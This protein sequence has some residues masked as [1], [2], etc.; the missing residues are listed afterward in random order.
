MNDFKVMIGQSNIDPEERTRQLAEVY[1]YILSWQKPKE[2]NDPS[3]DS[4]PRF[5]VEGSKDEQQLKKECR[6]E[7]V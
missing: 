4:R 7:K 3:T 5:P 1:E 6:H 2:K